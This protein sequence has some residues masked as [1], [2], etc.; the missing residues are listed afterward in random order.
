MRAARWK[1]VDRGAVPDPPSTEIPFPCA[2]GREALLPVLGRPEGVTQ[3]G[4]VFDPCA[5]HAV[6]RT[7]H[8]RNCGR[9][10]TTEGA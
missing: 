8:C 2:C 3:E 4:V 6:P 7:I 5:P 1:V 10:F 9:T